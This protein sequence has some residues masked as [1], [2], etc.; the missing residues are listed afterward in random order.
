MLGRHT[1]TQPHR[2]IK[3]LLV[4][5][6]FKCSLHAHQYTILGRRASASLRQAARRLFYVLAQLYPQ[7]HS[8]TISSNGATRVSVR[9]VTAQGAPG[10]TQEEAQYTDGASLDQLLRAPLL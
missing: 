5:H 1:I 9:R 6:R 8:Q 7:W 3:C 2:Q 10:Q 4:V